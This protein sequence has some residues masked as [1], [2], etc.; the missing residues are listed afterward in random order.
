VLQRFRTLGVLHG[1]QVS[2]LSNRARSVD[3]YLL[4]AAEQVRQLS[5]ETNLQIR[6]LPIE[7]S[8]AAAFLPKRR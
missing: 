3:G 8:F 5:V 1:E 2:Q 6:I 4:F 7:A